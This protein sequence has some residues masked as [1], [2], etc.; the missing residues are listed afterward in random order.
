MGVLEVRELGLGEDGAL[1][2]LDAVGT[3]RDEPGDVAGEDVVQ[4]D[5]LNVEAGQEDLERQGADRQV[6]GRCRPGRRLL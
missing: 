5:R 4:G 6:P 3:G 1:G 2:E